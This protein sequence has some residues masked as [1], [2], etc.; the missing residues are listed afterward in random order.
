M[1]TIGEGD[2]WSDH[3]M[4]LRDI[5]IFLALAEELH[6]GRTAERLRIAQASV[7]QS[8]AKQERAI[9]G[10]L[11]E[12]TSRT[13]RLT[14]LGRQLREDLLPIPDALRR[15][16]DRA[17]LTALG[18][19]AVLTVGM[20]GENAQDLVPFWHAFRSR[21]PEWQLKIR[22]SPFVHPFEALR[23]GDVDVLVAWLPVE[24][25]DLTVG[26]VICTEPMV[27]VTAA[28]HPLVDDKY[29]SME[30]FGDR[31][32]FGPSDPQP[33]YWENAYSP[34]RTPS[35]RAI[36][37]AHTVASCGEVATIIGTSDAIDLTSAHMVRY[38]ARP[39][40]AHLPISD[41]HLLRWGLVWRSDAETEP[42]RG[43]ARVVRDLG[44][45][46]Y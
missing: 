4:Q 22:H 23:R 16:L 20:I 43:L 29:V 11:F 25:P 37:R 28:N 9:G 31:G 27:A 8:I 1:V 12:R 34:F 14:S 15:S 30:V 7:S 26:P 18:G 44:V 17:A 21:H 13:V 5:E 45:L 39:D 46:A 38:G 35:G 32:L 3:L 6:F 10:K 42:V 19:T 40:L 33:A 2:Q 41:S 36:E 24:E